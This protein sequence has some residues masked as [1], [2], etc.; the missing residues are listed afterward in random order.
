MDWHGAQSVPH[1]TPGAMPGA[2]WPCFSWIYSTKSTCHKGGKRRAHCRSAGAKGGRPRKAAAADVLLQQPAAELPVKKA[3]L[4]RSPKKPDAAPRA[5]RAHDQI[6]CQEAAA[7]GLGLRLGERP[8]KDIASRR[9]EK[10]AARARANLVCCFRLCFLCLLLSDDKQKL[11]FINAVHSKKKQGREEE[12]QQQ[13][14]END[15]AAVAKAASAF[16]HRPAS[17]R[18][19]KYSSTSKYSSSTSKCR[20][21]SSSTCRSSSSSKYRSAMQPQQR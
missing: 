18:S 13:E 17:S 5:R 14:N 12:Q 8:R 1:P 21:S 2:P 11:A 7:A 16:A 15:K 4:V 20:S 9:E 3:V 19:S 10:A 6:T